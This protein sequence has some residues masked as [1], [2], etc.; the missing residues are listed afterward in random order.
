MN[1]QRSCFTTRIKKNLFWVQNI[2]FSMCKRER[3]CTYS[4]F[5]KAVVLLLPVFGVRASVMF[6]L[7]CNHIIF[8][9]VSC[10]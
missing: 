7:M 6:H 10:C 4:Q 2:L 5:S 8:I 3:G 1:G 9:S